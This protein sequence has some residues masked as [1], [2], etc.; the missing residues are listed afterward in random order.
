MCSTADILVTLWVREGKVPEGLPVRQ[1]ET[2]E[3]PGSANDTPRAKTIT[4]LS[5]LPFL[6]GQP[7]PVPRELSPKR[8]TEAT[9]STTLGVDVKQFP[10]CCRS[11]TRERALDTHKTV[12]CL[13]SCDQS[14]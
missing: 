3:G 13:K 7:I 11:D 9:I 10:L 8:P 1:K 14:R 5:A 12:N 2:F 4:D 6:G